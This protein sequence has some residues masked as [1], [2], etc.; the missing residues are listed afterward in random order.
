MLLNNIL[1]M[2]FC[3]TVQW[4]GRGGIFLTIMRDDLLHNWFRASQLRIFKHQLLMSLRLFKMQMRDR[5]QDSA[6]LI[7]E[8]RDQVQDKS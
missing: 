4:W 2:L 5:V 6:W 1:Y 8:H 3:A 7:N